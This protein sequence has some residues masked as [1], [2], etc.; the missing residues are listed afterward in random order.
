MSKPN[1]V[2]LKSPKSVRSPFPSILNDPSIRSNNFEELLKNRGL[3][4]IHRRATP[5]PNLATLNDRG[6]DPNCNLCQ[7]GFLHYGDREI[8]GVFYGDTLEKLYEIQGEWE[9]GQAIITFPAEYDTGEQADFN[10]FDQ[11]E[12]PDFTM[13]LWELKEFKVSADGEQRLRYPVINTDFV[14]TIDRATDTLV[15][16]EEGVDF[17]VTV[18]GNIKWLPGKEPSVEIDPDTGDQQGQIIT[19]SYFSKPRFTVQHL[20]HEL[21]ASQEF[22]EATGEKVARRLP[23]QVLV[24]KDFIVRP[25]PNKDG[26]EG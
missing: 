12:I 18:D 16:F 13:R 7:D 11:L 21:R 10:T 24:R 17:E 8:T 1:K 25:K 15:E 23:Q 5:C 4:F 3:R 26:T 19:Y 14:A 2:L 9:I 6:H 22:D 20:M